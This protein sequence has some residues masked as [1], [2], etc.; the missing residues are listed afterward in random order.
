MTDTHTLSQELSDF[1]SRTHFDDLPDGVAQAIIFALLDTVAVTAVGAATA[2][3][4]PLQSVA[5]RYGGAPMSTVIG[6]DLRTDAAWAAQ[7]NGAAG[8][9]LDYDDQSWTI[10]GHP[11]VVLLP[12]VLALAEAN[13]LS[14]RDLI[15]AYALGFECASVVGRSV[16]PEH[17]GH[18]WHTTGTVGTVGAACASAALLGLDDAARVN[19]IAAGATTATGLRQNFG[20]DLKPFHAGNAARAGVV[21]AEIGGAGIVGSP[22]VLDGRWG[23]LN[24]F[25]PGDEPGQHHPAGGELGKHWDL[26]DPGI[27]TKLFPSC[28]ATHPG[29]GVMLDLRREGLRAD[30]VRH[31]RV[32]VVDMTARILE[33]PRPRTGL[34]AKF[35]ME[36]CIARA[37]LSGPPALDHFA[38]LAVGDPQVIALLERTEMIVDPELTASWVW[39]TPRATVVEVE[40]TSGEVLTRRGDLPPGSPGNFDVEMLRAKF[41]DCLRRTRLVRSS[42]QIWELVSGLVDCPDV[43]ELGRL[44]QVDT[45]G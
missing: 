14:G 32:R 26:L 42:G 15:R 9:A 2:T 27:A 21:A 20:T 22:A 43:R 16:N 41:E 24:V 40:L 25:M 44:L 30:A 8:H 36:Y 11:S 12:A 31:I 1:I 6:T 45:D 17:Y 34:E 3:V 4:E 38:E 29:I 28:G 19:A 39:G 18:G 13:S 23:F 7:L 33:N 10:G 35:S 37:L 5:R